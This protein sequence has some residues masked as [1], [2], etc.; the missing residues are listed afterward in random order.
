MIGKTIII[1]KDDKGWN[2]AVITYK[3]AYINEFTKTFTT[4]TFSFGL[5]CH[6]AHIISLCWPHS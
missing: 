1:S 5:L 2:Y 6:L 4:I 3:V